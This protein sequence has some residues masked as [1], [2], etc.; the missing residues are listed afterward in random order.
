MTATMALFSRLMKHIWRSPDT[1]I[2]VALMPIAMMLLFVFVFG[3]ALKTSLPAGTNYAT[4]M[5]PGI[6]LMAVASGISYTAFRMWQDTQKGIFARFNAMPIPRAAALWGHVL[7]S[8]V[9]NVITLVLIFLVGLAVGVRSSAGVLAWLGVAGVLV[10]FTLALTWVAVIPGI[11]ATSMEGASAFS[12]PLIF[13]PFISSAF[14]PVETMPVVVRQFAEYQPVTPIVNTVRALLTGTPV[15]NN[16][17]I[18]LIWC[19]GII[20]VAYIFA[21]RAYRRR[22][23]GR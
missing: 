5:L 11:T 22:A 3:G 18:A 23:L 8:L 9:S 16:W 15:G 10:L 19:V 20:V 7:T 12:Y 14:V 13:L 17:W 6:L 2:T 21:M 4:Y 1:I